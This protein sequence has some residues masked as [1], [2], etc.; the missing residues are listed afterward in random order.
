MMG[1]VTMKM[2][3]IIAAIVLTGCFV[4]SLIRGKSERRKIRWTNLIVPIIVLLLFVGVFIG[5]SV[6][7]NGLEKELVELRQQVADSTEDGISEEYQQ[8]F[9]DLERSNRRISYLLGVDE[10]LEREIRE[11]GKVIRR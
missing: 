7:R 3:S 5:G 2:I 4:Y 1:G 10:D 9:T 6:R 11:L 8:K